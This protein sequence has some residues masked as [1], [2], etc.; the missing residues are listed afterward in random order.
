ME[1]LRLDAKLAR[2][3]FELDVLST[4]KRASGGIREFSSEFQAPSMPAFT[5]AQS[6]GDWV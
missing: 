5:S 6:G 4:S 1:E 3:E 2:I